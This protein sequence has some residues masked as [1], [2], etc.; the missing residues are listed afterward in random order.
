MIHWNYIKGLMRESTNSLYTY[1]D[2]SS[3]TLPTEKVS[4]SCLPSIKIYNSDN[5]S[6][7]R[8]AGY[9]ITSDATNQQINSSFTFKNKVTIGSNSLETSNN[10]FKM[11]MTTPW[12]WIYDNN[13]LLSLSSSSFDIKLAATMTTISAT[14]ATYSDYCKALYFN[15]TSDRRAKTNLNPLIINGLDLV[16][17]VQLYT[18]NY[19][20]GNIPS[21]GIIAQEVQ[22]IDINGFKLVD[23]ESA[24]G[25]NM[26]YMSIHES[27]LVYI[28]WKAV[29]ELS[30]EVEDLKKKLQ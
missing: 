18:F 7:A 26:D 20:E 12:S 21:I 27:K 28:L 17:K 9:I 19:K 2:F 11:T 10:E 15:A 3:A 14:S 22:D 13:K 30:A 16:K 6:S 1:I 24:T 25:T 23:N 29:Q 8:N 5:H 4:Q